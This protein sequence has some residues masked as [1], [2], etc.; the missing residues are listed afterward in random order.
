MTGGSVGPMAS[1]LLVG[2]GCVPAQV[3]ASPVT[4]Q[5]WRLVLTIWGVGMSPSTN[6]LKREFQDGAWKQQCP[7]GGVSFKNSCCQHLCHLSECQLLPNSPGGSS[8]SVS[9][10]YKLLSHYF[11]CVSEHTKFCIFPVRAEPIFHNLLAVS[12]TPLAFKTRL[13]V[14]TSIKCRTPKLAGV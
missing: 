6:E 10:S 8:R 14:V 13:S 4:S 5:D 7:G 2:G 9:G 1:S 11:F 3:A 12:Q